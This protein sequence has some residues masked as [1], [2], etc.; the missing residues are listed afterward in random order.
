MS[1][2]YTEARQALIVGLL[3][4]ASE[5]EAGHLAGIEPLFDAIDAE[6][7][8]GEGAEFD[9]LVIA[10]HFWDGWIDARNHDWHYYKGISGGNWPRLARSIVADLE[11]DQEISNKTVLKQFDFKNRTKRRK[12]DKPRPRWL[13]IIPKIFMCGI[14]AGV[15]WLSDHGFYRP[16][17]ADEHQKVF[18]G[19]IVCKYTTSVES[20]LGSMFI[21]RLEVKNKAGWHKQLSV[22]EDIYQRAELGMDVEVSNSGVRLQP[23]ANKISAR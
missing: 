8:L 5:Q 16:A 12:P 15:I 17:A 13:K 14:V 3:H 18:S 23:P 6:L 7:P 22:T 4:A 1:L 2:T 20:Q 9:K 11:A 19:T 21:R 10:L